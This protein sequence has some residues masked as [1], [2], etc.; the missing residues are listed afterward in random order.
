MRSSWY[1]VCVR[2]V[3]YDLA[4]TSE[5]QQDT[6]ISESYLTSSELDCKLRF[7]FFPNL[8]LLL[9]TVSPSEIFFAVALLNCC[10]DW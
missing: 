9:F 10:E 2:K 5:L 3:L 1:H 6:H 8:V 7:S 4:I